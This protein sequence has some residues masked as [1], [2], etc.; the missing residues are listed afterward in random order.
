MKLYRR[1][2]AGN[3][4][5]FDGVEEE[6]VWMNFI[7][8]SSDF[9]PMVSSHAGLIPDRATDGPVELLIDADAPKRV[10][11]FLN[12][13]PQTI[14]TRVYNHGLSYVQLNGEETPTLIDNL[15]RT[16]DPDIRSGIQF[17]KKL[18]V[19]RSEDMAKY[20]PY[21]GHA[22]MFLFEVDSYHSEDITDLLNAYHGNTPFIIHG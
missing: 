20:T 15:R 7:Q 21:E 11:V 2:E 22:D 9:V 6:L 5:E 3:L 16:I 8:G 18:S 1:S 14:V 19:T 13:M 4:C 17:I 10:G 12:E